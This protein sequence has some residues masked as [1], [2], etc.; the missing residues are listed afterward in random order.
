MLSTPRL[1]SYRLILG[2]VRGVNPVLFS[3]GSTHTYAGLQ[4]ALIL[5]SVS[6]NNNGVTTSEAQKHSLILLN[7][8]YELK[9]NHE[10]KVACNNFVI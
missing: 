9:N 2:L 1:V 3:R 8:S 10:D 5:L 6:A 4:N 7:Q